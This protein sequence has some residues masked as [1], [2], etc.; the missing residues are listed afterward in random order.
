MVVSEWHRSV[1]DWTTLVA[2]HRDQ[3]QCNGSTV[4]HAYFW[5]LLIFSSLGPPPCSSIIGMALPSIMHL[6]AVVSRF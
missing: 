4:V 1:L 6:V 2:L 3:G 5:D